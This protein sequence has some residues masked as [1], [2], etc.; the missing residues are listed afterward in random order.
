GLLV[1]GVLRLARLIAP[2][3]PWLARTAGLIA[4]LH[5]TLVYAATHVQVALLGAA[6]L[7]WTLAWGYR[8]GATGR[9]RDAAITGGWLAL[10]ALT[11]PI[12][13]LAMIGIAWAL[14]LERFTVGLRSLEVLDRRTPPAPPFVRGGVERRYCP[15]LTKGGI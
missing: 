1:W 14:W 5:P 15:P 11:D 8:T 9:V 7:T 12:L 3:R 2:D 13:S 10:L 4:A 6:L